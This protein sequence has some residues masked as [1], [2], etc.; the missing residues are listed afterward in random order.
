[1]PSEKRKIG[2]RGEEAA[3]KYLKS[4]GYRIL[5]RNYRKKWGELD[6]VA[7]FR[8]NIVFVEVKTRRRGANFFP[9]QNVN[10]LKQ[11]RLIRAAKTWLAENRI[12][13]EILWQIDVVVVEIDAGGVMNGIEHLQNCVWAG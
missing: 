6:I 8:K 12:P 2:D 10:Y 1:M 3:A 9:A 7:A 5:G 4:R 11:Q 13:P